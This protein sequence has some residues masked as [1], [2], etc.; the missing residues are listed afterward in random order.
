VQD[1]ALVVVRLLGKRIL[2][3]DAQVRQDFAHM[4]R[5]RR[6]QRQ[7]VGAG[8][9]GIFAEGAAGRIAIRLRAVD[10]QHI[11]LPSL[12]SF[13]AAVRPA[14]PEPRM[15]T[16]VWITSMAAARAAVAQIV[17]FVAARI[18]HGRRDLLP[19]QNAGAAACGPAGSASPQQKGTA[20]HQ[21]ITRRQSCSNSCTSDWVFRRFGAIGRAACRAG[22]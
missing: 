1:V 13:H 5:F 7:I 10:H 6:R 3:D 22:R 16:S 12:F 2:L 18:M 8:R 17:A 21:R 14:T 20:Q 11:G 4:R 9:I 15:A 19:A